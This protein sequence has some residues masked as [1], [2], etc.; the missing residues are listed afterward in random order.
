[1]PDRVYSRKPSTLASAAQQSSEVLQRA[2]AERDSELGLHLDEVAELVCA[3]ALQLGVTPE[4]LDAAR[5]TALLHDVGKIA[6]P[7]AILCKPGPLDYDEWNY[8]KRHTVIGERIIAAAP[9]LAEVA[10]YVRSTHERY[11][12]GGYPDGLAGDAI[13]LISRIVAVCDAYDAMVT[14]RAYR[15]ALD[16][17]WA[18]AELCECSGTQFDPAVVDGFLAALETVPRHTQ[19]VA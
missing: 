13:P 19:L 4:D 16:P 5:D 9:A 7:D 8:M 11:D 15:R 14:D 18:V 2:L 17:G 1:M 6:I 12:G 10:G 3:T